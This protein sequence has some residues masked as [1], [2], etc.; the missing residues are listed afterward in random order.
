LDTS[1]REG[2]HRGNTVRVFWERISKNATKTAGTAAAGMAGTAAKEV[3]STKIPS[4]PGGSITKNP[5]DGSNTEFTTAGVFGVVGNV[6]KETEDQIKKWNEKKAAAKLA[7]SNRHNYLI[8]YDDKKTHRSFSTLA[9]KCDNNDVALKKIIEIID[10]AKIIPTGLTRDQGFLKELDKKCISYTMNKVINLLLRKPDANI[11]G[12]ISILS[13]ILNITSNGGSRDFLGNILQEL[14]G[15]EISPERILQT[16]PQ[17]E[18]ADMEIWKTL[19]CYLAY[20]NEIIPKSSNLEGKPVDMIV[21]V[22]IECTKL[23]N[24]WHGIPDNVK[25]LVTPGHGR[26]PGGNDTGTPRPRFER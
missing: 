2:P 9:T 3:A 7:K 22:L 12:I 18:F 16:N 14:T 13:S 5:S 1:R 6:N 26:L 11:H 23:K 4:A 8:D 10:G 25:C 17:K 21:N 19:V 15:I 24:D 20:Q